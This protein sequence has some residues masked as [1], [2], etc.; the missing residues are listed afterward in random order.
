[1]HPDH[2]KTLAKWAPRH[3]HCNY[4]AR[5]INNLAALYNAERYLELNACTEE[6]FAAVDMPHKTLVASHFLFPTEYYAKTGCRFVLSGPDNFFATALKNDDPLAF[7]I[8]FIKNQRSATKALRY[9]ESSMQHA[10]SNTIWLMDNTLPISPYT[11]PLSRVCAHTW[12][13]DVFKAVLLIH[14]AHPEISYCTIADSGSPQT[15][16]WQ[17]ANAIRKPA[18]S[19]PEEI[20]ALDHHSL[21]KI[22]PLLMPIPEAFLPRLI[23]LA[24][25]PAAYAPEYAWQHLVQNP[26]ATFRYATLERQ[27]AANS[28]PVRKLVLRAIKRK[29]TALLLGN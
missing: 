6:T 26:A 13:A 23:G 1:M 18:F 28:I 25:D 4:T 22:A 12:L 19:S 2:K 20:T 29:L 11:D 7:D 21:P 24:L 3:F 14:D 15:I 17:A 5:C 27:H 9:F 10:H 8:I 16:F